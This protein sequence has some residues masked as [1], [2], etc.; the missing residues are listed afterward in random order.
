MWEEPYDGGSP[1]IYYKVYQSNQNQQFVL[2]AFT[3][4]PDNIFLVNNGLT[5]GE[6]YSFKVIA[7]NV[8]G[9]SLLSGAFTYIAAATPG[10]PGQPYWVSR[11]STTID[12]EWQGAE[13]YGSEIQF[14]NIYASVNSGQY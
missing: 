1:I 4:G 3:I 11:S 14:Y 2:Y 7:V 8:V 13:P 6:L 5:S 10:T 9:E 12:L